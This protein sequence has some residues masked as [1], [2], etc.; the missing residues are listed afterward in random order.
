MSQITFYKDPKI[1]FFSKSEKAKR[2]QTNTGYCG[3]SMM[4]ITGVLKGF[5]FIIILFY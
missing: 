5:R 2:I 3:D 1:K 4:D